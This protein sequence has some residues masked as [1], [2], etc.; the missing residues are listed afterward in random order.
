MAPATTPVRASGI[1]ILLASGL[2]NQ[3]GAAVGSFAFPVIGPA[4]V[5]AVRQFVAAAVLLPIARPRFWEFRWAQWWPILLLALVF[6]TM[7][8]TLYTSIS[9]VGLGLAVTLEFLGPL[10]VALISSRSRSMLVFGAVA[11]VGVLCITQPQPTTDFIGIGLG[12]V[13]AGCWASYIL[14]NRMIGTRVPG[15]QGTATATAV[16][17][18]LFIPV[19]II[20]LTTTQPSIAVLGYAVAAGVLASA[21]PYVAD[22]LA[23]RRVPAHLFSLLM[24]IAPV[25][26]ALVGAVMLGQLLNLGEW[27]GIALIVGTNVAALLSSRRRATDV[28]P[29]AVTG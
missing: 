8:L 22:L 23:L 7:N 2:S 24:S 26:A 6:G 29:V 3:I 5:V 14:L 12:L 21:V 27:I 16:S 9:R 18:V 10:F 20:T 13:A 19:G 4:G 15:I 11:I 17:A 28:D 1:A 25:F